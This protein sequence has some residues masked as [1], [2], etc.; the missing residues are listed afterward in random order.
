MLALNKIS[1]AGTQSDHE[2]LHL[3]PLPLVTIMRNKQEALSVC[4]K[5]M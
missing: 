5:V 3:Q 4:A 2:T 1:D